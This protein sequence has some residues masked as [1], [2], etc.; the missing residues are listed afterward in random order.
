MLPA[1]SKET[2]ESET[3]VL[4]SPCFSLGSIGDTRTGDLLSVL[5]P[6]LGFLVFGASWSLK[7]PCGVNV[8]ELVSKFC[9]LDLS[10]LPSWLVAIDGDAAAD[11]DAGVL[12]P[13]V[14]RFRLRPFS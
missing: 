8:E 5:E 13:D 12:F 14:S 1:E 4:P 2:G 9:S 10:G 11:A 7:L 3:F 6:L